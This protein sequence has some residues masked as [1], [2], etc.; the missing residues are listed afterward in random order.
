MNDQA[1]V[2]AL[3]SHCEAEWTGRGL[4]P[5]GPIC[6]YE[7]L[8]WLVLTR[9]ALEHQPRSQR[10]CIASMHAVQTLLVIHPEL[11]YQMTDHALCRQTLLCNQLADAEGRTQIP[12]I[13]QGQRRGTARCGGHR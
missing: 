6:N 5:L 9:Q 3:L 10:S 12:C 4:Y 7:C 8:I 11:S 13:L 1:A 2:P